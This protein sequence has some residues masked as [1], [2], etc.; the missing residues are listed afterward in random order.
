MVLRPVELDTTTDPGT[1]QSHKGRFD[2]VIV[3]HKV[4][5][6]DLVVRHLD[7]STQFGHHHH[8]DILILK[9]HHLPLV[10]R[11]LIGYRLDDRIRINHATGTLI[12]S[13]F[14]EY[15]VLLGLPYFIGRYGNNFSPSFYHTNSFSN[16]SKVF[17]FVS[18]QRRHRKIKAH[19]QMAL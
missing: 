3:I 13:F 15:R 19:T 12:D 4:A 14:Q 16:C 2:N 17:P 10:W 6:L 5:L 1:C 18:G 8:F 7:T 9:E 11:G